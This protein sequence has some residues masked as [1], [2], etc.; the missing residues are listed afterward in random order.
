MG[1]ID[2]IKGWFNKSE[3]HQLEYDVDHK[4]FTDTHH[5]NPHAKQHMQDRIDPD[6]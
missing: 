6:K 1:I 4:D 3:M 2:R 5:P